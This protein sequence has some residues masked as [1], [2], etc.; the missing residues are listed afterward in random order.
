M[1]FKGGL[2]SLNLATVLQILSSEGKTGVLEISREQAKSSIYFKRGKIIAASTGQK[3][4]RIG[5]ILCDRGLISRETLRQVLIKARNTKKP[6][7]EVVVSLG[8]VSLMALKEIV[9]R[10]CRD[11]VLDVFL[12]EEG[13]FEFQ[14]GPVSFDETMTEAIEPVEI[15]LEA[16]RRMDEW[17]VMKKLIPSDTI[18]FRVSDQASQQG[19]KVTLE[20]D[21]LR[22]LSMLDGQKSVRE[23]VRETGTDEFDVYK[24]LYAMAA[25]KLIRATDKP[26]CP[27]GKTE[28]EEIATLAQ[29]YHDVVVTISK[30]LEEQLGKEFCTRLVNA[31]KLSVPMASQQILAGYRAGSSAEQNVRETLD[32]ASRVRQGDGPVA[33]LGVAFHQFIGLLLRQETEIL[34]SKQT[35]RTVGR[36]NQLLEVVDKYRAGEGKSKLIQEI[37]ETISQATADLAR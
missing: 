14:E 29:I 4:L 3:E 26:A 17:A 5:Q 25:S 32:I 36:I 33:A 13:T 19:G 9:R 6:V 12:W 7:G 23:V 27:K 15:I 35:A 31:C 37:R 18:V 8:F 28:T 16:A 1:A 24:T 10:L 21:E 2:K 34:G 11:A 20:A 30:H 22:L